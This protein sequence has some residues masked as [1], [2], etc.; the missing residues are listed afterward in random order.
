VQVQDL[1]EVEEMVLL[2]QRICIYPLAAVTL[3]AALADD[4]RTSRYLLPLPV[5]GRACPSTT[6]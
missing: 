6:S 1:R 5:V 2:G 4:R 3:L